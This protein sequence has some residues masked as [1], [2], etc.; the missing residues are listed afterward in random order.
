M[1]RNSN[2]DTGIRSLENAELDLVS[3]GVMKGG[4]IK[5]PTM[6]AT[7]KTHDWTFEDQFTR[8]VIGRHTRV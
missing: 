3:G 1:Y 6:P 5:L 4:C 2:I 8:Y 7:I